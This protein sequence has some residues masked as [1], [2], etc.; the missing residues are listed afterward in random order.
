MSSV[1]EDFEIMLSEKKE[2]LIYSD[3]DSLELNKQ[4]DIVNCLNNH[5]WVK[6]SPDESGFLTTYTL[7]LKAYR[8]F[9]KTETGSHLDKGG[10]GDD[11][12][13]T[14][15]SFLREY[16]PRG[17]AVYDNGIDFFV[18]RG[19]RKF[20]GL[21]SGDEDEHSNATNNTDNFCY[22]GKTLKDCKT[23]IVTNKSNGENGKMAIRRCL[24]D[25]YIVF[26][27]SKNAMKYWKI[28]ET[29]DFI[30]ENTD[31]SYIPAIEISKWFF[32]YLECVS[33]DF[34]K[35]IADNEFTLMFEINHPDSE[36]IFPIDIMRMDFVSILNK[37][38]IS[39]DCREAFTLFDTYELPHEPYTI[40]NSDELN[41]IIE[42]TRSRDNTEGVVIYLYDDSECIGLLKIKTDFYVVA[43][44]IRECCKHFGNYLLSGNIIDGPVN[45]TNNK[46]NIPENLEEC[47][48]NVEKRIKKRMC[49]LTHLQNH[50]TRSSE[51][52]ELG[53]NFL[54]YYYNNYLS[55]NTNE[56]KIK[57]LELFKKKYGTLYHNALNLLK[58]ETTISE[59]IDSIIEEIV[60]S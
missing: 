19:F 46:K 49:N 5:P 18:I 53:T 21:S 1:Y 40:H 38:G 15:S 37:D 41:T 58:I 4:H 27:G 9:L 39:I 8:K 12:I 30:S 44:A 31:G 13:Y 20:T 43:R 47:F 6:K 23:I 22:R 56:E 45:F 32:N 54:K 34:F 48:S 3:F 60:I 16:M 51:W 26:A 33:N 42:N 10:C 59:I 14:S 2:T 36:H 7:N 35:N 57:Y 50:A 55:M 25:T 11:A 52:L 29:P 28:G 17:M 24:D